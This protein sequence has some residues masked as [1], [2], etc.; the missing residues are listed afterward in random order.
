[1]IAGGALAPVHTPTLLLAGSLSLAAAAAHLACIAGGP[2][3]YLAMGA[4]AGMARAAERGLWGP[5]LVTLAIAM[6]LGVWGLYA[7]SGAGLVPRLPLLRWVLAGV[8][9]IYLARGLL[10]FPMHVH[11][12]D[13][14]PTFWYWSSGLC[15]VIGLIHLAGLWQAWPRLAAA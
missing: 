9:A 8:T 2:R 4:G 5:T 15:A 14:S 13:N 7:W 3:W 10:F 1:M 6:V 12:P 11:F